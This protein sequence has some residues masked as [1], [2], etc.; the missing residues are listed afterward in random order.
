M[1]SSRKSITIITTG[2]ALA[3]G[4]AA[5]VSMRN[6]SKRAQ[7]LYNKLIE[8][9]VSGGN[10]EY[11]LN[12]LRTYIYNHM[13]TEIGSE[14]GIQP[15]IQ[16]EGTFNRLVA[17]EQARVE[18]TNKTVYERAQQ[19]CEAQFG[20]GS[21]RS[22]RVQCVESYVENNTVEA[23]QVSPDL[24]RF[25]FVPP[26]WSP[27]IAGFSVLMTSASVGVLAWQALRK[28]INSALG[29]SREY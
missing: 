10:V 22:G 12:E 21:L 2:L 8:A 13:N 24:Y 1:R 14:S 19:S 4:T 28:I 15:P 29:S 27:D 25:D 20:A 6:N 9:D 26:V 3:S 7:E 23:T 11:A 17:A 18:T 16:L 5:V